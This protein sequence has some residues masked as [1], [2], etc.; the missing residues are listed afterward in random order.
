MGE[1]SVCD[2][3]VDPAAEDDELGGEKKGSEA[4]GGNGSLPGDGID[5]DSG[6]DLADAC[7]APPIDDVKDD[8]A[9]MDDVR[10][11]CWGTPAVAMAAGVCDVR[12]CARE[13]RTVNGSSGSDGRSPRGAGR[14]LYLSLMESSSIDPPDLLCNR[15]KITL[16]D[17]RETLVHSKQSLLQENV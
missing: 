8:G 4:L 5:H 17:F 15:H 9:I 2:A 11:G 12:I 10:D 3:D 16:K 1:K 6:L 7:A 14:W 13:M